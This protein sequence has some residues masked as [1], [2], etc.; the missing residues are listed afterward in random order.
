MPILLC[1]LDACPVSSSQFRSLNH[2]AVS[3]A[4]KIFNVNTSVIAAEC[5]RMCG[6][7]DIADAVT[8]RKDKFIKR[9]LLNSS[10][11][12]EICSLIVK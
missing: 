6:V 8:T 10:E 3:C 12:C 7:S 4:R 2:V 9:H 1:G 5:I 11:V